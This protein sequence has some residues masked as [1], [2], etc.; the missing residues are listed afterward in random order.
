M[1]RRSMFSKKMTSSLMKRGV[2]GVEDLKLSPSD[3]DCQARGQA[4]ISLNLC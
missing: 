3:C 4:I 2:R 1:Q